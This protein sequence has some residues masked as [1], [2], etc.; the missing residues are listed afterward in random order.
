MTAVQDH[1]AFDAAS[2]DLLGPDLRALPTL[3]QQLAM[4]DEAKASGNILDY[5]L[6]WLSLSDQN[7]F[8]A[9][10][11]WW[12]DAPGHLDAEILSGHAV[13]DQ[14]D[15]RRAR[16]NALHDHHEGV[17]GF[18]QEVVRELIVRGRYHDNRHTTPIE[19]KA[20]IRAYLSTG[21]RLIINPDPRYTKEG[22]VEVAFSS[23]RYL[24]GELDDT[25]TLAAMAMTRLVRRWR[26]QPRVEKLVRR[27]GRSVN[28][29]VVLESRS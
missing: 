14:F 2:R 24:R 11:F 26:I 21:G 17:A 16:W 12:N 3:Q 15:E 20:V 4:L 18:R 8:G 13:D 29:W 27:L 1:A 28:G 9:Q 22:V 5:V 10:A 25:A 7:G 19:L 23:R 6:T